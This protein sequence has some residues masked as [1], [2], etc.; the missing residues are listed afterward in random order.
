M[1]FTITVGS[2]TVC[3][4]SSGVVEFQT[5]G[6]CTIEATIADGQ[7]AAAN[8][9]AAT[10]VSQTIVAGK[11][12]QTITFS[13]IADRDFGDPSFTAGA[14]VSSGRTVTYASPGS[15]ASV[16]RVNSSTGVVDILDVGDCTITASSAGDAS[17]A[18]AP[19]VT[20]TLSVRAVVPSKTSLTSASFGDERITV[21]FSAPESDGGATITGYRA[22]ATPTGG[23]SSVMQICAAASPCTV[24]GLTN[25]TEYE[26]TLAAINAAGIGVASDVSPAVTPATAPDSVSDLRTR[27]AD[28]QLV[29]QWSIAQDFGGGSFTRYEVYLRESGQSWPGTATQN[30]TS[31]TAE[32]VTLTGLTNGQAYDVKVVTISSVNNTEIAGTNL[33]VAFGV[34]VT[35]PEAPTG[36]SVT[37]LSATTALASWKAPADNGGTVVTAYSLTPGCTFDNPT[38][39]FCTLTGLTPRSTLTVSVGAT[40]FVGTGATT[41][42]VVVMPAAPESDSGGSDSSDNSAA[43]NS[44]AP[45]VTP[46]VAPGTLPREG[47]PARLPVG[48]GPAARPDVV[49]GPMQFPG[50]PSGPLTSPR[51]FVGGVPAPVRT[52]PS[53]DGGLDIAAGTMRLGLRPGALPGSDVS[54]SAEGMRLAVPQGGSTA[55]SGGGLLPGS[56]LQVFLPG[57]GGPGGSELA[58]L[59]VNAAGEFDGEIGFSRNLDQIPLPIGEQVLQA[60]GYDENGNQVVVELPVNIAQ[61]SPA[62]EWNREAGGVPQVGFGEAVATSAGLPESV[63]IT[64][65][66][67]VGQV[68]AVAGE[69]SFSVRV[70]DGG[71]SVEQAGSGANVRLIQD[72]SAVATGAGFEPGTRVDVWLFSDPTLLGSVTVGDDGEFST[73]F[74]LD[75]RFATLGEHTLQLQGVGTDGFVKA[76]NLGVSIEEAFTSTADGAGALLWWALGVF[77]AIV[78]ALVLF[79]LRSRRNQQV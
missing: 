43:D 58:R 79:A 26:V 54:A 66:P 72:R 15:S 5:A 77:V 32:T 60:V 3:T 57:R 27:P 47:Q 51:G 65:L 10:A 63:T 45:V 7:S 6:S 39:T 62:P 9:L 25:G 22:L 53:S 11:I 1:A 17:Y 12:N 36:F 40:N 42:A 16:C 59:S 33:A 19:D 70:P 29:V 20:R 28:Q 61:G 2:P 67:E 41:T 69:W 78:I 48:P 75:P 24:T 64:A 71:G 68:N 52:T 73:E 18:A 50:G 34:P 38:D 49:T 76:V 44:P 30:L 8:Y 31:E 13:A 4:L 55:V 74:Y 56:N 14:T 37:A 23:G 35:V 21:G 46:P